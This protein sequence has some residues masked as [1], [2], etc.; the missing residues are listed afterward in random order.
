MAWYIFWYFFA[1]SC[2]TTSYDYA[3]QV[4]FSVTLLLVC[5]L[6]TLVY[7]SVC[8]ALA[9]SQLP[10]FLNWTWVIIFCPKQCSSWTRHF[11]ANSLH[12]F[13]Q[14]VRTFWDSVISQGMLDA[15][16]HFLLNQYCTVRP[17]VISFNRAMPCLLKS[18]G[19][20]MHCAAWGLHVSDLFGCLHLFRP[21]ESWEVRCFKLSCFCTFCFE[22]FRDTTSGMAFGC[23]ES[24]SLL[25]SSGP[26]DKALRF[27]Y[28]VLNFAWACWISWIDLM[29]LPDPW[30]SLLCLNRR[31]GSWHFVLDAWLMNAMMRERESW[32]RSIATA[33]R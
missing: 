18:V 27:V 31:S 19:V 10:S 26:K 1:I 6:C 32:W 9:L 5:L 15:V 14:W 24:N 22:P 7:S 2:S 4:R 11:F 23:R 20:G 21:A 17:C 29:L 33:W 16:E 3:K 13:E 28:P 25:W 8:L 12:S 30:G